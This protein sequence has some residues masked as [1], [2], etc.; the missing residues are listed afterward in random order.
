MYAIGE[1]KASAH[2]HSRGEESNLHRFCVRL[3]MNDPYFDSRGSPKDLQNLMRLG[4][5]SYTLDAK[6][7]FQL[8]KSR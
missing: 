4:V 3:L 7:S 2:V 8:N 1:L 5:I 6:L